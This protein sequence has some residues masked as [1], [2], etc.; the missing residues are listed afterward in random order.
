MP[1]PIPQ[2]LANGA[3]LTWKSLHNNIEI[4]TRARVKS[5]YVNS[6]IIHLNTIP[7]IKGDSVSN[8]LQRTILLLV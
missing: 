4:T 7:L 6:N 1:L 8:N 3:C 2:V 5:Q